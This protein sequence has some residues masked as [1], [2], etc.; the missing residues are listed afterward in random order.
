M[1]IPKRSLVTDNDVDLTQWLALSVANRSECNLLMI[2]WIQMTIFLQ[3]WVG[4]TNYLWILK[5]AFFI[6]VG[7]QIV[8]LSS[9]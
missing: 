8:T 7:F 3:I 6:E 2:F 9:D 5:E 4:K 1:I